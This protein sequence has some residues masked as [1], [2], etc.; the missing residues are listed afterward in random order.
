MHHYSCNFLIIGA[1]ITG[2]TIARELIQRGAEDI[3]IIEKET[4]AGKHASGRNSGVLHAGIYYTPDSLKAKFCIE[5]NRLMK[6]YCREK[7]LKLRESGKVIVTKNEGELQELFE[8]KRRADFSGAKTELIDPKQL[9]EIEPFANTVERALYSPETA[10]INPLEILNSLINELR[11]NNKVKFLFNTEFISLNGSQV[12][13]TNKGKIRFCKVINSAGAYAEKIAHEFGLAKRYKIL[14][15]R[16]TYKELKRE[17]NYLVKGNIYPVP[18]INNPFLGVHFTRSV[19]DIVY[20]GPT[21]I[22][23]FGRENYGFLKGI[24]MECFEIL[25][26]NALLFL[27]DSSFR[28][29]GVGE[30]KKYFNYFVFKDAVKLVPEIRVEDMIPSKK[31]GIRPQLIGLDTGKLIMDFVLIEDS[32]SIHILNAVSPA[33]TSSMAFAKMVCDKIISRV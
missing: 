5:G 25:F 9:S 14:P 15:F 6:A 1:G 12:I 30:I 20:I 8:L 13:M 19:D 31:V 28:N 22:P 10:V 29:A 3:I 18:D 27:R 32:D 33:F 24:D 7:G 16:G 26:R 4:T 23:A 11:M 2:L 21:A 17:R